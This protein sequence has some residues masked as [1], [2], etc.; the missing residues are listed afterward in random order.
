MSEHE[1]IQQINKS[2]ANIIFSLM[3]GIAVVCSSIM[4][5]IDIFRCRIVEVLT[6]FIAPLVELICYVIFTSSTL[7]LLVYFIFSK[8]NRNRKAIPLIINVVIFI[9]IIAVP[10]HAITLDINFRHHKSQREA[11]VDM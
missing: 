7:L 10:F 3:L 11:V 4:L 5:A 9:L 8:T 1:E 2:Q 6:P